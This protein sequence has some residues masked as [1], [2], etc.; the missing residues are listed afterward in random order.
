MSQYV[1]TNPRSFYQRRIGQSKKYKS[2]QVEMYKE[3]GKLVQGLGWEGDE[4]F[5]LSVHFSLFPTVSSVQVKVS[6]SSL[7]HHVI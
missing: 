5:A 1:N 4:P 2:L 3:T 6:H 7:L